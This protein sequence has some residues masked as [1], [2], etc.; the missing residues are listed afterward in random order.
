[1]SMNKVAMNDDQMDQ[2]TGGTILPYLVQPG[3]SLSAIAKKFNVTV[4][5]LMRWNNIQDPNFLT[6][7]QQLKIKF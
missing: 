4:E 6:V 2:V 7:G 1:M 3:D 5:Q